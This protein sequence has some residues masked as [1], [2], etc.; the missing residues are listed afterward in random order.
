M[1]IKIVRK[2][3]EANDFAALKIREHLRE[4]H[5]R[6]INFM[7]APGAGKTAFLEKLIPV[8]LKHELKV[9]VIEGDIT[10]TCDADR[11]KPLGIPVVQINTE[12]FG[13]DCH[14]TANTV[15][16]A[17]KEFEDIRLNIILLENVGNLVCPAEFD[18]GSDLNIV[19]WSVTE[20]EDKPLKY[21]LM[22]QKANWV[23]I[24]K[25]DLQD[26]VKADIKLMYENLRKINPSLKIF[27]ISSKTNFNIGKLAQEI[28]NTN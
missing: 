18:T 13:G 12:F 6:M 5:Q 3:L 24:T 20:G 4:K 26:A 11:L 14:L 25:V 9:G 22:F 8:L 19:L 28:V 10:T 15:F 1:E 7:S 2:I 21:P 27:E 23:L 16:G 17:L